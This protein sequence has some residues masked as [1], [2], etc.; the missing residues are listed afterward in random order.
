MARASRTTEQAQKAKDPGFLFGDHDLMRRR[1]VC[2]RRCMTPGH[3]ADGENVCHPISFAFLTSS[4]YSSFVLEICLHV[5]I[6]TPDP[7]PPWSPKCAQP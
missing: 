3:I 2:R 1:T 4:P 7:T 5:S 6:Y